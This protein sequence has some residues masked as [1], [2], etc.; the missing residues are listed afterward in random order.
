MFPGAGR[1]GVMVVAIAPLLGCASTDWF[2]EKAAKNEPKSGASKQ[3]AEPAAPISTPEK[4]RDGFRTDD[5]ALASD[6]SE[7]A[8]PSDA[9]KIHTEPLEIPGIPD[10][11]GSGPVS[12]A[13][14]FAYARDYH[15][16]LRAKAQE[17]D[18]ARAEGLGASLFANPQLVMDAMGPVDGDDSPDLSTRIDFTVPIGH[19]RKRG[20]S[21]AAAAEE[22]ARLELAYET[23]LV[24]LEVSDAA[25][26][27]LYLQELAALQ[28]EISDINARFAKMQDE[29]A[30]RNVITDVDRLLADTSAKEAEFERLSAQVQLEQA[31]LLLAQAMGMQEPRPVSLTGALETPSVP[32]TP[33]PTILAA[34][35]TVRPELRAGDWGIREQQRRTE[36]ARAEAIPDLTLSPRY[37]ETF[38]DSND[39]LGARFA[40]DLLLWN[41]NQGAIAETMAGTRAARA[42]RQLYESTTL[43]D[44]AQAYV[45]LAPLQRQL[46]YYDQQVAP[47][48]AQAIAGIEKAFQ[49]QAIDAAELSQQLTRLAKL[50]R[51][52]LELRYLHQ[53]TRMRIEILLRRPLASFAAESIPAGQPLPIDAPL[54]LGQPIL[55]PR[56]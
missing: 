11:L 7:P 29:R 12:I 15:P 55:G 17:I 26:T 22:R 8:S 16:S 41:W 25:A 33:L 13:Q 34:A 21:A 9:T 38:N 6:H 24:L 27:V 2:H 3:L 18:I 35:R 31:R 53:Q 28:Q 49:A 23:D 10:P 4:R 45:S 37:S 54:P 20:M 30:A 42:T 46:D 48:M 40:S 5:V 14:V 39:S 50:R 43:G 52:H 56:P 36:L 19:K 44:I 32:P 47:A 1:F 51:E